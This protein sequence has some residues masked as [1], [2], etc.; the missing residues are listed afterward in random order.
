[1]ECITAPT[2]LR[3]LGFIDRSLKSLS[4]FEKS[5]CC[6]APCRLVSCPQAIP[7]FKRPLTTLQQLRTARLRGSLPDSHQLNTLTSAASLFPPHS[8]PIDPRPPQTRAASFKRLYRTR[9]Q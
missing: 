3:G 7:G 1:M 2:V 4:H 9:P 5:A 6:A 8:I